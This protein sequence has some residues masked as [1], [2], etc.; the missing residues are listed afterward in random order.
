MKMKH[1]S[2]EYDENDIISYFIKRVNE[3]DSLFSHMSLFSNKYQIK[4]QSLKMI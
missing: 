3:D 4:T 2:L 1:L